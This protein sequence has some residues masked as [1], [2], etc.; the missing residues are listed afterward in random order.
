MTPVLAIYQSKLM[1][2]M[3]V[4][5]CSQLLIKMSGMCAARH[6]CR[7][8]S[9]PVNHSSSQ[10]DNCSILTWRVIQA[11]H[12]QGP[13]LRMRIFSC[14]IDAIKKGIGLI[15]RPG[16]VIKNSQKKDLSQHAVLAPIFLFQLK[17]THKLKSMWKLSQ[18]VGKNKLRWNMAKRQCRGG[19]V[20]HL[21]CTH[22]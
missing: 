21:I 6:L 3:D 1:Y 11:H 12:C 2:S 14:L 19:S 8:T 18:P 22:C 7:N 5:C 16:S 17:K 15:N 10:E 13:I 4:M 20:T 9:L